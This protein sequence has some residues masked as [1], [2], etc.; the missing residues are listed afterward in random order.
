V[1]AFC[2]L[3]TSTATHAA[4]YFH[5]VDKK[6]AL[7]LCGTFLGTLPYHCPQVISIMKTGGKGD[8][9]QNLCIVQQIAVCVD[10]TVQG[11]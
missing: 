3:A 11:R 10:G 6:E 7:V 1:Q 2:C 5:P 9:E 8:H 4:L